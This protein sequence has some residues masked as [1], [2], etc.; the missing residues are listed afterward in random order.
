MESCK[1]KIHY[2]NYK[3]TDDNQN[4]YEKQVNELITVKD[5]SSL[6]NTS[7]SDSSTY[8]SVPANYISEIYHDIPHIQLEKVPNEIHIYDYYRNY[9]TNYDSFANALDNDTDEGV[10][11]SDT[12]KTR[13]KDCLE[14]SFYFDNIKIKTVTKNYETGYEITLNICQSQKDFPIQKYQFFSEGSSNNLD[15]S[16]YCHFILSYWN[17]SHS[18]NYTELMPLGSSCTLAAHPLT[19]NIL[20]N[21]IMNTSIFIP[22]KYNQWVGRFSQTGT[23]GGK[24]SLYVIPY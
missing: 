2:T 22:E 5:V 10:I 7:Q 18:A 12:L 3:L 13:Y 14:N 1:I 16:I 9:L 20:T 6:N 24:L 23:A 4:N 21:S 17:G 19:Y 11:R 8:I 15:I